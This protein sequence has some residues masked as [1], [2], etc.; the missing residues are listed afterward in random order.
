MNGKQEESELTDLLDEFK[1]RV[2]KAMTDVEY[3]RYMLRQVNMQC[4]V[5]FKGL[6]EISK[7][8][9]K[10]GLAGQIPVSTLIPILR[11]AFREALKKV[12]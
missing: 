11:L 5:L 1:L 8:C 9:E 4:N 3:I 2:D 6:V 12:N 7:L 10:E